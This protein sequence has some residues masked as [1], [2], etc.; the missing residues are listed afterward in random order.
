VINLAVPEAK[1]LPPA[2]STALG[3]Y[4]IAAR[5]RRRQRGVDRGTDA[6]LLTRRVA[7]GVASTSDWQVIVLDAKGDPTTQREFAAAMHKAGRDVKLFPQEP[8]RYSS[9]APTRTGSDSTIQSSPTRSPGGRSRA[10]R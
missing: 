6:T 4:A 3:N 7:Y 10:R 1:A 9:S 2:C 8:W 5:L